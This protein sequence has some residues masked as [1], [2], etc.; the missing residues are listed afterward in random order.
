MAQPQQVGSDLKKSF[1]NNRFVVLKVTDE[2]G[3]AFP[4][5]VDMEQQIRVDLP[6]EIQGQKNTE[7]IKWMK[8][9]AN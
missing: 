7:I 8:A 5:G 6:E 4:C 2:D 1:R 9:Q 3:K